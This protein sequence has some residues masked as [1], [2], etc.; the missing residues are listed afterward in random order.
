[1]IQHFSNMQLELIQSLEKHNKNRNSKFKELFREEINGPFLIG[2][3]GRVLDNLSEEVLKLY[4]F[5]FTEEKL[6]TGADNTVDYEICKMIIG[7]HHANN[8]FVSPEEKA[9]RERNIQYKEQLVSQV[10]EHVRLRRYAGMRFR[11]KPLMTGERFIYY[12]VPYLL[13]ALCTRISEIVDNNKLN[14]VAANRVLL[15]AYRSVA[16]LTLL[17]DGFLDIAYTPCRTVIE[18]F[19]RLRMCLKEPSLFEKIEL[20]QKYE[21]AGDRRI[22]SLFAR[23]YIPSIL[24]YTGYHAFFQY[25]SL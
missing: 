21:I 24:Y 11:Q 14:D 19:L 9:E 12:P 3:K 17:E 16:S 23:V 10:T 1:M 22:H 7:V 25:I 13:F 8:L 4:D 2:I 6:W 18:D 15:I 5:V 20:F